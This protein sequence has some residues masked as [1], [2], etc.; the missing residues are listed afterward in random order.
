MSNL[1][2]VQVSDLA[3]FN[4]DV[5]KQFDAQLRRVGNVVQNRDMGL[6]LLGGESCHLEVVD[7]QKESINESSHSFNE[8]ADN[9]VTN[10][11]NNDGNDHTERNK[12]DPQM[13]SEEVV[14]A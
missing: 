10:E 1:K 6:S 5:Y 2:L 14:E 13:A 3:F 8:N 9:E 7:D 11:P 4:F 12:V